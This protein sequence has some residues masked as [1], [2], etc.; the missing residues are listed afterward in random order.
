MESLSFLI[1]IQVVLELFVEKAWVGFFQVDERCSI[2]RSRWESGN[3]LPE[4]GDLQPDL[5][6]HL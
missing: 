6:C 5:I 3:C 4:V 1:G 2:G